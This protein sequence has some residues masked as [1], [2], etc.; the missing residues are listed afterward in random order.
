MPN[1]KLIGKQLGDQYPRED[2]LRNKNKYIDDEDAPGGRLGG[3][4]Y[5]N[6]TTDPLSHTPRL[7]DVPK[8]M[9]SP[10]YPGSSNPAGVDPGGGGSEDHSW[11][12]FF[13]VLGT[14]LLDF[15]AD[16]CQSPSRAYLLD[17]TL[18]GSI[19]DILVQFHGKKYD[20]FPEESEKAWQMQCKSFKSPC[21]LLHIAAVL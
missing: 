1:G 18:P 7:S 15:D 16:A 5:D 8:L 9:P 4:K 19:F 10:P 2:S 21:M 11:G 20:F 3:L 12:I 17:V 14:V 13:T 6:Y